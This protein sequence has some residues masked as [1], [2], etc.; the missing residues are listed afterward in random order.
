MIRN[1][2]ITAI[3]A[4]ALLSVTS[5]TESDNYNYIEITYNMANRTVNTEGTVASVTKSKYIVKLDFNT[6]LASITT[7]DASIMGFAE[8]SFSLTD[9]PF[10]YTN[11]GYY[12]EIDNVSPTINGVV[13]SSVIFTDV[14]GHYTSEEYT[15]YYT[16]DNS[17]TTYVTPLTLYYGYSDVTVTNLYDTT[18]EAYETDDITF[19]VEIDPENNTADLYIWDAQFN[20]DMPALDMVFN[21]LTL[22]A[23][24]DGYSISSISVVPEID[25]TPYDDY[26]AN[27][28]TIT[29][30]DTKADILFYVFSGVFQVQATANMNDDE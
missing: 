24:A 9:I 10:E 30:T 11:G 27:N 8:T 14:E 20:E 12:F 23:T 28:L 17:Y 15:F 5:C 7:T 3:T 19:E 25:N 22:K 29:L 1:L 18:A 21:D 26:T 16:I 2:L 6:Y 4:I 13:D